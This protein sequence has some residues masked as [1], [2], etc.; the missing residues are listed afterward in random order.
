MQK[1]SQIL[2]RNEG[3]VKRHRLLVNVGGWPG[4]QPPRR[5]GCERGLQFNGLPACDI[6][7]ESR[8]ARCEKWIMAAGD[9]G[10]ENDENQSDNLEL[11][12]YGMLVCLIFSWPW[13]T[14]TPWLHDFLAPNWLIHSLILQTAGQGWWTKERDKSYPVVNGGSDKRSVLGMNLFPI[15]WGAINGATKSSQPTY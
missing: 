5:R 13:H 10:D 2:G 1:T 15:E 11:G 9:L 7:V 14:M 8:S 4:P 12:S 6:F 3:H